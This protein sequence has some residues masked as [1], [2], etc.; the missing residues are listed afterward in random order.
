[1][2]HAVIRRTKL[3]LTLN[4]HVHVSTQLFL[5]CSKWD[6]ILGIC[7]MIILYLMKV[8]QPVLSHRCSNTLSH[9]RKHLQNSIQCMLKYNGQEH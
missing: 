6:A 9:F 1:M 8:T 7:V 4:E 2:Y 3:F 5:V